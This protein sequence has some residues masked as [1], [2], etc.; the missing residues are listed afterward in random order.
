M[1]FGIADI[2]NGWF[3]WFIKDNEKKVEITASRY[4]EADF[5][6]QFIVNLTELIRDKREKRFSIYAEPGF[7]T[8]NMSI[9]RNNNFNLELAFEHRSDLPN[10]DMQ[11]AKCYY[12]FVTSAYQMRSEFV[13]TIL[14]SFNHYQRSHLMLDCYEENWTVAIGSK[15]SESFFFPFKELQELHQTASDWGLTD[16]IC[17]V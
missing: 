16:D 8:I 6:K 1:E 5:V 13:P 12:K 3:Y 2:T 15:N 14:K 11:K 7:T 4:A 10:D 9:D 17:N